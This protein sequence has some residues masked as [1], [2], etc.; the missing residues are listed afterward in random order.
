MNIK[1]SVWLNVR[2]KLTKE[3]DVLRVKL[4]MNK[5]TMKKLIKEQT[6]MK[7]EIALMGKLIKSMGPDDEYS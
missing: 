2:N 7:R 5:Y 1:K 4:M 6:T 3:Q